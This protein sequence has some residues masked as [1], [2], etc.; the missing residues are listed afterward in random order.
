M[1]TMQT[2]GA[3]AGW[4]VQPGLVSMQEEEIFLAGPASVKAG[5]RARAVRA[6]LNQ[7]L[8]LSRR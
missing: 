3:K 1:P 5:E 4:M 2:K 6:I 7:F 8:F